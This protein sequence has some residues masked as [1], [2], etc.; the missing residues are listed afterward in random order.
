[1]VGRIR[2][3]A[4]AEGVAEAGY[5]L[6][7]NCGTTGTEGPPPP[8]S[9]MG[10]RKLTWPRVELLLNDSGVEDR[11]AASEMDLPSNDLLRKKTKKFVIVDEGEC[12]AIKCCPPNIV[13]RFQG[14]SSLIVTE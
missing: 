12:L 8:L 7:V 3:I 13:I 5:R 1:V 2:K 10:G 11:L 9:L 14:S 6:I 4:V